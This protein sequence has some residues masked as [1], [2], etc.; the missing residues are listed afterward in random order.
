[1]AKYNGA[2]ALFGYCNGHG[3][4]LERLLHIPEVPQTVAYAMSQATYDDLPEYEADIYYLTRRDLT[5]VSALYSIEHMTYDEYDALV[6][7]DDT[8]MYIIE[9]NTVITDIFVKD[10]GYDRLYLN[11]TIIWEYGIK[12]K[13]LSDTYQGVAYQTIWDMV[14]NASGFVTD[15]YI[16][17][18]DGTYNGKPMFRIYKF[19]SAVQDISCSILSESYWHTRISMDRQ[20]CTVRWNS[21]LNNW[22]ASSI[23]RSVSAV[24]VLNSDIILVDGNAVVTVDNLYIGDDVIIH[25]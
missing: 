4:L 8:T 1:M 20:E 7:K 10:Y 22:E 18:P 12:S 17:Y 16:I 2:R 19:L 9:E 21:R 11:G 5:A 24:Y 6:T 15:K 13:S 3:V 14:K 23:S 25:P